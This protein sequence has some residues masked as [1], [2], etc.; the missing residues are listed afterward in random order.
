MIMNKKN[1]IIAGNHIFLSR[2]QKEALLGQRALA[3]WLTGLPA[4]GKTSIAVALEK[5]LYKNGFITKIF[6]GDL[7][8]TDIN[9][10]LGFTTSDRQKNIE[11]IALLNRHFIRC[12]IIVINSFVSPT[13]DIRKIAKTI[14]GKK[15]FIEIFI[16]CPVE[17]CES[18]DNKGLYV[19]ARQGE[20]LGFTGVDSPYEAP[21]NP[22]L[23]IDT[24]AFSIDDAVSIIYN[25]IIE[26]I[27]K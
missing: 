27:K 20:L 25:Y 14:I 12:G 11:R 16:D 1:N 22:H 5:K 13:K 15:D 2:A 7:I 26:R 3:V 21:E 19:K 24:S 10:D 17:V 4:S 8:R 23:K 9:K 18:R 6:D